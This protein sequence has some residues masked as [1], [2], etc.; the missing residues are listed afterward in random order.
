[1]VIGMQV[2][3]FVFFFVFFDFRYVLE[4]EWK[5]TQIIDAMIDKNISGQNKCIDR[6]ISFY[7]VEIFH[8]DE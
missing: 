5:N 8:V 6:S 3:L 1:M 2:D 7:Q 4:Y